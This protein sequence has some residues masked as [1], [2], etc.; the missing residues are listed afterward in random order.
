[1]YHMCSNHMALQVSICF[2]KLYYRKIFVKKV[3]KMSIL[4]FPKRLSRFVSVS[5]NIVESLA[6]P[7]SISHVKPI[8]QSPTN[9]LIILLVFSLSLL[10][11]TIFPFSVEINENF[12]LF[13]SIF[14]LISNVLQESHFYTFRGRKGNIRER[15][16][17]SE[18]TIGLAIID[19]VKNKI[20]ENETLKIKQRKKLYLH[21]VLEQCARLVYFNIQIDDHIR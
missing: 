12:I 18:Q 15:K 6:W 7:I 8:K 16:T 1:M 9:S 5:F 11:D 19:T 14:P 10:Y 13:Y 4:H 21:A 3:Q 20:N 2:F 17:K